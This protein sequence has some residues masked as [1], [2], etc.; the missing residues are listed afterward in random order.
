MSQSQSVLTQSAASPSVVA[1]PSAVATPRRRRGSALARREALDGF[2]FISP[3]LIGFVLF[4]AGP[5][6][7]SF[8]LI[9]VDWDLLSDPKWGGMVN[10][11]RLTAD[12]LVGLSLYNTAYYTLFSVPLRLALALGI[13]ILLNASVRGLAFWRTVFYLP[14]VVPAVANVILW[15]WMFNPTMGLFNMILTWLGLP[16]LNWV[17]DPSLSKPSLILMSTWTI[18]NVVIIFLAGLQS[19]PRSLYEAAQ[20]DG[21]GGWAQFRHVTLPLISPVVLFNLVMGIIFSFQVF[22]SAFL[23]TQGGPANTTL[24]T[25]L[26]LYQVAF[27]QFKVGYASAIAWVLFGVILVF[28][29]VQWKLADRWVYYEGKT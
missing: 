18:G 3:W 9:F 8:T 19:V 1:A 2:L 28:T 22:T 27:E 14:A 13:A 21:G 17:W 12:R 11:Q 10:V 5:M 6:I 15:M 26:Y 24:F 7:A 29:L 23:I 16:R 20:I 4:T 25:V